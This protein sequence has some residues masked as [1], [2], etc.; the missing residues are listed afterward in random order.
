MPKAGTPH[1]YI[2]RLCFSPPT[3]R[4]QHHSHQ[5]QQQQQAP[6]QS[7]VQ[8][9]TGAAGMNQLANPVVSG[10]SATAAAPPVAGV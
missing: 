5:Q 9:Q 1:P 10:G 8:D 3:S 6:S 4:N 2:L 7:S